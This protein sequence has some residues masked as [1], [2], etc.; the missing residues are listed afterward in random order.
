MSKDP[1][2]PHVSRVHG[3]SFFIKRFEVRKYHF[4]F[5]SQHSTEY[6]ISIENQG[7][8]MQRIGYT[9]DGIAEKP[10]WRK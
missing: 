9:G 8:L 7:T 6:I 3:N 2:Q 5:A 1:R 10:N 4:N